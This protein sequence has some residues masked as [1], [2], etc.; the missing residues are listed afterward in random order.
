MKPELGALSG[1]KI[2]VAVSGGRDSM[3]LLHLLCARSEEYGISVCALNCE[4]GLRGETSKKD[5][6][7]V[8]NICKDWSVPLIMFSADCRK[9]AKERGV[10]EEVA[11]RDWRRSCYAL[12]ATHFAEGDYGHF[13][14]ATAHHA[15]DNAETVLFNIARGSALAG[16]SGIGEGEISLPE[17]NSLKVRM[18]RPLICCTRS[19]IDGYIASENIPFVED[20]TNAS[21]QFTRNYIRI[22]VLPALEKSV[23]GAVEG[24]Y[25]F[26]RLALEDEEYFDKLIEKE[27]LIKLTSSGVEILNC[28][29]KVVFR[30]AALKAIKLLDGQIKDYTSEHM[31]ALF[32]LQKLERGKRFEFCGLV[33]FNEGTSIGICKREQL[34]P[35]N[36][37]ISISDYIISE[38]C[39]FCGIE[40]TVKKELGREYAANNAFSSKNVK[41]LKLDF[42]TIPD[43]AVIRFR[44]PDDKFKKFGSGEKSLNDFFTDKKI[45]RRLRDRIPVLAC[46][47]NVLAVCGVEI[48]DSVKLTENTRE[49]LCISCCDFLKKY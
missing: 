22:N 20:E 17:N 33:A 15:N 29:E 9:L 23:S 25:R 44:Q 16:A 2:C 48:A 5:S 40:M 32:D 42:S 39:G 14:I 30:R 31:Q 46:K 21:T 37:S 36:D 47:N 19:E 38:K 27:K 34:L 49:I 26:S 10:G 24:I 11:A 3:A 4:H 8:K 41:I 7:F 35:V 45:S 6:Q 13:A 43:D 1:M 12:A 18:V 28:D